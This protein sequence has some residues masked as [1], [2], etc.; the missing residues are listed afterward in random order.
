MSSKVR[1]LLRA[2]DLQPLLDAGDQ[3][4][5][6][7]D[8]Q[9]FP[10]LDGIIGLLREADRVADLG[11]GGFYDDHPFGESESLDMREVE[12]GVEPELKGLLHGYAKTAAIL[13]VGCGAGRIS[14]YL[15]LAGYE[16]LVSLDFSLASLRQVRERT[17]N[18]CIWGNNLHLPFAD[19]AFELVI[20]SGVAHHTPE[21]HRAIEECIRVL[22]PGGRLYLR[23]YNRRSFYRYVHSTYGALLRQLYAKRTW[24]WAGELLGFA[25]FRW[26]RRALY[27]RPYRPSHILRGKFGNL[28][29]K[30]MVYFFD[31]GELESLLAKHAMTIESRSQQGATH[32]MHCYVARRPA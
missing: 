22:E 14:N 2:P 12:A 5:R 4:F 19:G 3:G 8:G 21:P 29:L 15:G 1:N 32:R 17:T 18:T 13:D 28:F 25:L 26:V 10:I 20:T 16:N 6:A 7:P 30:P 11:D 31:R 24:R 27:A 9:H 23:V